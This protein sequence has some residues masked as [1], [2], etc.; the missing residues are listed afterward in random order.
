MAKDKEKNKPAAPVTPANPV[1]AP[2]PSVAALPKP[3]PA[4]AP[5]P[6]PAVA[7]TPPASS[8]TITYDDNNPLH[9]VYKKGLFQFWNIQKLT[10]SSVKQ[11]D[12]DRYINNIKNDK[13]AAFTDAD[14][15]L[16][17]RQ[18]ENPS[19][20]ILPSKPVP[21]APGRYV[22]GTPVQEEWKSKLVASWQAIRANNTPDTQK[23]ASVIESQARKIAYFNDTDINNFKKEFRGVPPPTTTAPPVPPPVYA[24]VSTSQPAAA[25]QPAAPVQTVA[26]AQAATVTAT[27]PANPI[28]T[29]G[30]VTTASIT[31][32][33]AV[34]P[35]AKGAS[36]LTS[37]AQRMTEVI[38]FF[39][40]PKKA[41]VK[42]RVTN[43]GKPCP[44]PFQYLCKPLSLRRPDDFSRFVDHHTETLG[45][46]RSRLRPAPP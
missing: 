38:S 24:P 15:A 13:G 12:L 23:Q 9:V 37:N 18:W 27:Q 42:F 44:Y 2:K 25:V 6:P 20:N 22:A 35:A 32:V 8:S 43:K 34:A 33:T 5:A 3:A 26:P 45:H 11:A 40:N 19:T 36:L 28:Q 21:V 39:D 7:T 30:G 16:L 14:F 46:R 10:P 17:K 1:V 29:G 31:P 4:A 41:D